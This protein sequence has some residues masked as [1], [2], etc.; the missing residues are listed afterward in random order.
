[1]PQSTRDEFKQRL[2]SNGSMAPILTEI[3][4]AAHLWQLGYKIE[5]IKS[6]SK[7]G[8]RSPEFLATRE[9]TK[10]E[11]ECKYKTI[12]AG[13]MVVSRSFYRLADTISK[14]CMAEKLMGEISISVPER[15]PSSPHWS[16]R[17][18]QLGEG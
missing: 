4:A 5:W 1:M 16:G 15:I 17:R 8:T 12:D 9:G 3:D 6:G 13:R 18:F 2:L 7:S 10:I 14:L 11:V